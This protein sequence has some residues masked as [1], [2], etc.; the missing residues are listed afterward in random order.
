MTLT[1]PRA[2]PEE[3]LHVGLQLWG[4]SA[5]LMSS[6]YCTTI[7]RSVYKDLVKFLQHDECLTEEELKKRGEFSF[8]NDVLIEGGQHEEMH[9]GTTYHEVRQYRSG[10]HLV[11]FYFL[12]RAYSTYLESILSDFKSD[13]QPDV[14]MINSCVWDVNRYGDQH[15]E[16]YKTN[17]HHLFLRLKEVLNPQC[18]ILWT[19]TMPVGYKDNEVALRRTPHNVR[20]DMVEG[21][22]FSATLADFH[23]VD[24]VDMHYHFR[25][26]LPHR[27]H[28]SVHWDFLAHRKYSQILLSHIACAWGVQWCKKPRGSPLLP[29]PLHRFPLENDPRPM[30]SPPIHEWECSGPG[31]PPFGNDGPMMSPGMAPGYF[32]PPP[33]NDPLV[34]DH[35]GIHRGSPRFL[36]LPHRFPFENDPRPMKSPPIYE[37]ERS[38]PGPPPFGNDG[39]MMNP[40]MAPGYFLP[41]PGNDPLVRD[42]GGIHRGSPFLFTRPHRFPLENDQ[43]P[44]M[45]PP[46]HERE[47]C[48]PG[49]PPILEPLHRFPLEN[50]PRPMMS[51][52]I[53]E[54][55]RSGPAPPPFADGSQ[56]LIPPSRFALPPGA[57]FNLPLFS[58][59]VA[60]MTFASFISDAPLPTE[61]W[62]M[63]LPPRK[64]LRS[65]GFRRRPYR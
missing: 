61:P 37:R 50:D 14:L 62:E 48:G 44:R 59:M 43:C 38:G 4:A 56:Q 24:V 3:A 1:N 51:P 27:I 65:R 6:S 64:A 41:P 45:S 29:T 46:I 30:M 57:D 28:D 52:P 25:H 34:R 20:M 58:M 9:N 18:L 26:D 11:R 35:G 21:N 39:P 33:G 53:H 40:N 16:G 55:E 19:T 49:S 2:D 12:T 8:L 23:K 10:H 7:Q 36:A 60:H 22:F 47:R 15:L 13:P 32:L 42:H 54:W 5:P 63:R 17:L 31:P